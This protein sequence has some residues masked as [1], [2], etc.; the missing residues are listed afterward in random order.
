MCIAVLKYLSSLWVIC[1][2]DPL[3]CI[4]LCIFT[5]IEQV[6]NGCKMLTEQTTPFIYHGN[7]ILLILYSFFHS[8][9]IHSLHRRICGF[10]KCKVIANRA[11]FLLWINRVKHVC[12]PLLKLFLMRL[13]YFISR[14]YHLQ[15]GFK[16]CASAAE[17]RTSNYPVVL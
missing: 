3:L 15:W 6:Q 11:S 5:F 4:L 14:H 2:N 7:N 1:H 13:H 10:T 9:F 17:E 16:R 8:L 12:F